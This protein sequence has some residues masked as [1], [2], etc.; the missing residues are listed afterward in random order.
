M[1]VGGEAGSEAGGRYA[2]R[3]D[4]I[5]NPVEEG[6]VEDGGEGEVDVGAV[7]VG[8]S[9]SSAASSTMPEERL[10]PSPRLCVVSGFSWCS[11]RGGARSRCM[12]RC[13]RNE[14]VSAAVA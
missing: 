5:S 3:R 14:A 1:G 13:R 4:V 10:R 9:E 7:D 6:A 2:L 8:E 11:G 12:A